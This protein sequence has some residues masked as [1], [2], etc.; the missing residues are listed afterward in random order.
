MAR[1]QFRS[2]SALDPIQHAVIAR[3]II[4][5]FTYVISDGTPQ[6]MTP[7]GRLISTYDE[8]FNS[9]D[10][11]QVLTNIPYMEIPHY[12]VADSKTV[13]YRCPNYLGDFRY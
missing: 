9:V 8:E 5:S 4:N 13:T 6:K 10:P 1:P 2:K 7:F 11:I 3:P 12:S